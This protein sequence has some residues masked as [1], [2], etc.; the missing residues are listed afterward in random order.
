MEKEEGVGWG[1]SEHN[2]YL[3][4]S[5]LLLQQSSYY[6]QNNK[7]HPW[8]ALQ[9]S[10]SSDTTP[11]YGRYYHGQHGSCLAENKTSEFLA[12]TKNINVWFG[13]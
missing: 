9:S 11:D 5:Q 6:I 12:K 8:R 7:F 13:K 1:W 4:P 3:D 10:A 2:I